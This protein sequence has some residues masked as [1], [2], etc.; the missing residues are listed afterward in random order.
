MARGVL[1]RRPKTRRSRKRKRP[2]NVKTMLTMKKNSTK[3]KVQ[4]KTTLKTRMHQMRTKTWMKTSMMRRKL[5]TGMLWTRGSN[6]RRGNGSGIE[7]WEGVLV[8]RS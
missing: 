6:M 1:S 7:R 3:Q 2:R 5:K 4:V 8:W